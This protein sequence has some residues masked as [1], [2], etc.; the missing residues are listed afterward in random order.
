MKAVIMA[1]GQGSRLRPLTC[2][3]PKPMARLCGK[4]VI[5]YILELLLEHGIRDI[6]VTTRYLPQVIERHFE[7]GQFR[8]IKLD[9]VRED[10][11]LGTAGGVKNAAVGTDDLI[12]VI[13]GDALCDFDLRAAI[14]KH[15]Q[16]GADATIVAKRVSDP[17]EYGLL[18]CNGTGRVTGFVEKPGWSQAKTNLANTGIYIIGRVCLDMIPDNKPFDF[19]KDLFP[20]MLRRGM[21]IMSHEDNG[22]WCDIGDMKTYLSCQADLLQGKTRFNA[23]FETQDSCSAGGRDATHRLSGAENNSQFTIV[24]PV[25]IGQNVSIGNNAVIGPNAVLDDHCKVAAGAKIRDSVLLARSCVGSGSHLTGAIL[26]DNAM[27]RENTHMFEGSA[28]GAGAV[29]GSDCKVLSGVKIWPGKVSADGVT[30]RENLKYAGLRDCAFDDD[31]LSGETGVLLT[32]QFCV[33]LGAAAG[34]LK[35]A[36]KIGVA[37]CGGTAANALKMA[38]TSGILSTGKTAFDFG[39]MS[40]PKARFSAGFCALPLFIFIRGGNVSNIRI[41]GG[42]GLPAQRYVEREIEQILAR[43]EFTRASPFEWKEA[44]DM[45]GVRAIYRQ[46][47]YSFAP[48]GMAGVSIVPRSP[49]RDSQQLFG[50]VLVKLG[51]DTSSGSLFQLTGDGAGVSIFDRAAGYIPAPRALALCCKIHLEA[52][53]DIALPGDAPVVIDRLAQRAGR[54][55]LRYLDCPADDCDREARRLA[56]SQWFFRDGI[57]MSLI[58]LEHLRSRRISLTE[59]L[60]DIPDFAVFSRVIPV[61]RNPAEIMDGLGRNTQRHNAGNG[62]GITVE[63]GQARAFVRPNKLGSRLKLSIEAASAEIADELFLEIERQVRGDV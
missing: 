48:F 35:N 47:L 20:L 51:G 34:S 6:S 16:S 39:E 9:F 15:G 10:I 44:A 26:C 24:P 18:S 19:A 59:A 43:D 11:P 27:V 8:G 61:R 55:V 22:Y 7:S 31:G 41:L 45:S 60:E 2:D 52:G 62:E 28:A 63:S 42:G 1:G 32:P 29:V 49:D 50:E 30:V 46:Q 21:N 5:E 12:L 40:L 23:E 36:A 14:Q 13:S 54:R 57:A 3:I 33:K 37:H 58:I 4:P 17:R 25:Y 53:N 56:C 38:V